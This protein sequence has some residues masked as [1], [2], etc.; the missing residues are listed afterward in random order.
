M[1]KK[2]RRNRSN[3]RKVKAPAAYATVARNR[4]R[5]RTNRIRRTE[6]VA[7]ISTTSG[8]DYRKV[9]YINPAHSATFPWLS[10]VAKA[11]EK[12]K[13][14]SIRF[15][16]VSSV[17]TDTDGYILLAPDYDPGDDNSALTKAELLSFQDAVRSNVWNS[18][19]LNMTQLRQF[20]WPLLTKFKHAVAAGN[21]SLFDAGQLVILANAIHTGN[22]GEL[23]VDYD[24]ELLI[25]Q[26]EGPMP[27]CKWTCATA[28]STGTDA[29]GANHYDAD[30]IGAPA[31]LVNTYV[32]GI[33]GA[34]IPTLE[35]TQPGTYYVNFS[36]PVEAAVTSMTDWTDVSSETQYGREV[37]ASIT[38]TEE[39]SVLDT[40]NDVFSVTA[41]FVVEMARKF[42]WYGAL[43]A[44]YAV[45]GGFVG[46]G[47]D[48]DTVLTVFNTAQGA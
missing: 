6:F 22:I 19:T 8:V 43:G 28:T 7:D 37:D 26:T 1:A 13:F 9:Y 39:T 14:H 5:E 46:G 15:R 40:V 25:P 27:F 24:I 30:H 4:N 21:V 32:G 10:Q 12:Y 3:V 17:A 35:F 34:T 11:Y 36:G 23:W 41:K 38:I 31:G 29:L 45:Y 42:T 16:Y 2:K 20:N 33:Y 44:A 18:C 47:V 48:A